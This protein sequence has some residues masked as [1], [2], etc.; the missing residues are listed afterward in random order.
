MTVHSW[1]VDPL[2]AIG[3]GGHLPLFAQLTP[4]IVETPLLQ[5]NAS[6][7]SFTCC[8]EVSVG[9]WEVSLDAA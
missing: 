8:D 1:M 3:I 9:S 6:L 5:N 2:N 4:F 7:P